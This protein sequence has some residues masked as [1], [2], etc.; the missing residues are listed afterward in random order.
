MQ[1]DVNPLAQAWA[2]TLDQCRETYLLVADLALSLDP[3]VQGAIAAFSVVVAAI[4]A[5]RSRNHGLVY[6]F[7][8]FVAVAAAIACVGVGLGWLVPQVLDPDSVV[9]HPV[10]VMH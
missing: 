8:V 3:R 2:W 4:A 7:I 5:S 10:P 6:S 1:F 9:R